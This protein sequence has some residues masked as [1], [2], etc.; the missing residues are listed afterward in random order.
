MKKVFLPAL[1]ALC[2]T[3]CGGGTPTTLSYNVIFTTD[4]PDRM[5]DLSLATRHIVERRLARLDGA[6]FDYDVDYDEETAETIISV[7]VDSE[8]SAMALNEEMTAPF[9]FEVRTLIEGEPEDGDI[10]VERVG[11]FRA[12]GIDKTD[13]DWVVG[14]TTE[15]PLNQGRVL[16]GFTDE[17]VE[18]AKALFADNTDNTIGMFVRDRLAAAIQGS[19]DEFERVLAITGLP[20]GEIAKVFADD[21][22]VGIHMTFELIE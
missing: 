18:K 4:N 8:E 6:L 20:S 15:P 12:S 21:M 10:P 1:F 14:E 11:Y 13:I 9:T 7:E 17:G 19:P 22:N 5:T 2:L 16:I 3:A